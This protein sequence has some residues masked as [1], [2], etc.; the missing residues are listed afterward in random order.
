MGFE[1]HR[2]RQA[3]RSLQAVGGAV[4]W[5][6]RRR[7]SCSE[8]QPTARGQQIATGRLLLLISQHFDV[9]QGGGV[10]IGECTFSCRHLGRSLD[11]GRRDAVA[12]RSN[13]AA[14]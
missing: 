1:I 13:L 12:T 7:W 6:I 11:D 14:V 3:F 5:R 9:G 4:V 10:L 2:A 8:N